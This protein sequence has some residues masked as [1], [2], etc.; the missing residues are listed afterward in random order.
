MLTV[1]FLQKCYQFQLLLQFCDTVLE[2]CYEL[3][4]Q[5][6]ESEG[7]FSRDD[8]TFHLGHEWGFPTPTLASELDTGAEI[9]RVS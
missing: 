5:R 7:S 3:C 9:P 8:S 2:S 6:L 4:T 1:P